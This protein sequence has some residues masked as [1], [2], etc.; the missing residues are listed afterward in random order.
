MIPGYGIKIPHAAPCGTAK[1]KN[2]RGYKADSYT[3]LALKVLRVKLVLV[4]EGWGGMRDR[5]TH[6]Q[7]QSTVTGQKPKDRRKGQFCGGRGMER[8][9]RESWNIC[10]G[11]D[12]QKQS[13]ALSFCGWETEAQIGQATWPRSLSEVSSGRLSEPCF[14][15][16]ALSGF[17]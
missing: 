14:P 11:R 8:G 1:K 15:A 4:T 13:L 2:N 3:R 9:V 6:R 12:S 5:Q 7:V 17:P 16:R 10:S